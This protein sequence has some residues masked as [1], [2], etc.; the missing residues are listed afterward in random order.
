MVAQGR[1]ISIYVCSIRPHGLNLPKVTPTVSNRADIVDYISFLA[2][3]FDKWAEYIFF[4]YFVNK[5]ELYG[6]KHRYG[7]A[8]SLSSVLD[9]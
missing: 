9:K 7:E 3:F 1:F 5:D 8:Y 2:I 4:T 6:G